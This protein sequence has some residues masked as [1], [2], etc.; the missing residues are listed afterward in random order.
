MFWQ[1]IFA[2]RL[3]GWWCGVATFNSSSE[4][5]SALCWRWLCTPRATAH[6]VLVSSGE[7]QEEEE[8]DRQVGRVHFLT[9]A[10]HSTQLLLTLT[11]SQSARKHHEQAL[12]LPLQC[13]PGNRSFY[14]PLVVESE[15]RQKFTRVLNPLEI[16]LCELIS[17][18]LGGWLEPVALPSLLPYSQS[19]SRRPLWQHKFHSPGP[20]HMSLA[21][22]SL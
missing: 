4:S 19:W 14:D 16:T 20:D 13:W 8:V 3:N 2:D 12:S 7:G 15:Y 5:K 18:L 11:L 9:F 22:S 10:H 1:R 6:P 17:D 21:L